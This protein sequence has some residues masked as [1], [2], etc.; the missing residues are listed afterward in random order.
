MMVLL[1]SSLF[2]SCTATKSAV[3]NGLATTLAGASKD[4]KQNKNSSSEMMS[5]LTG[6][7]DITL[8]TDFFPT[9]LKIYEIMYV[10]NPSHQGL[11]TM[12][13]S[14]YIMYANAFV[15]APADMLP[16]E[17]F[18]KQ[19]DEYNRAKMHYL[20]GRD[21]ALQALEQR[22]PGFTQKIFSGDENLIQEAITQLQPMDTPSLYWVGAGWL[23]AFSLDPLDVAIIKDL[24]VPVLLLEKATTFDEN[25]NKGAIWDVLCS[26]YAGAPS[27]FGG[28]MQKA[29]DAYKKLLVASNNESISAFVTYAQVFCI[30]NQDVE[31]FKTSLEKALA[32]DVN[33]DPSTRLQSIITQRKA[34]YL[35]DNIDSY[36]IIW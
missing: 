8:M 2:C 36:F 11:A 7:T 34:Q 24:R 13:G 14:L 23:G 26:F 27:D 29:E 12:L 18:E 9:A 5:V 31:G 16:V 20:R 25:Y 35:L 22:Y 6:E 4:G 30:P 1:I 32:F 33:K 17:D 15:Q 10:Q 21:Y 19:R 3:M 28:D